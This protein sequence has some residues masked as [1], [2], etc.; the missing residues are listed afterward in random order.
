MNNL[1]SLKTL[2]AT[3]FLIGLGILSGCATTPNPASVSDADYGQYP[4]NY[5]QIVTNYLKTKPA[6][7]PLNLEKIEFLNEP[8]KFIFNQ[9]TLEKT[10]YRACA[11]IHTQ[12][13]RDLRSHFFLINNGKVVQHLHDSGLV[14]LSDKYCNVQMLA[15][16]NRVVNTPTTVDEN[17]FKYITCNSTN[18]KE[19]FFALN[20]EKRQLQQQHD[21]QVVASFDITNLTD[22]FIVATSEQHHISINRVSGTLLHKHN[23]AET[24]A[25]CKLT[26]KQG[27]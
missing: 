4:S 17:G 2:R 8:N 12:N 25:Q 1:L 9:L 6:R 27:F 21:G 16:E 26:N 23:G 14:A 5:K 18:G 7:T 24:Q 13:A 10:G 11:L 15:L 20:T 22:T 19:V 3:F